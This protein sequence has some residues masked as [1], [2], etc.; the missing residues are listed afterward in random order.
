MDLE[1][2]FRAHQ[3]EIYV[4]LYRTLGDERTA[5][6]L[7]QETFLR[8]FEGMVRFRGDSSFRTWLFAIARRVLS[9]WHRRHRN[10]AWTE[11]AEEAW[12]PDPARRLAIE[13]AFAALSVADRE[14]LAL[15]DVLEFEPAE[16]AAVIGISPNA[17]RVRLHRARARFR[18]VYA[19][20]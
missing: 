14:A 3:R 18:E 2:I 4:Y 11:A 13:E 17:F 5:E 7:A 6:D 19:D 8:A 1:A 16:A 10:V 20:G 9:E 12:D 15:C